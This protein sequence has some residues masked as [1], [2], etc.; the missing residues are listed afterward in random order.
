MKVSGI[1]RFGRNRAGKMHPVLVAAAIFSLLGA[2]AGIAAASGVSLPFSSDGT[3]INGCYSTGGQLKV[4]TPKQTTCPAG[5]TPIQ[6]NVTGPAGAQGPAG[7]VGPTG[8]TGP[9][10]PVG[11]V[12]PAGPTGPTGAT[13]P[14]GP[15]GTN[16]AAGQT[17]PSGEYVTGFDLTGNIVCASLPGPACPANS[18]L[19]FSVTS[20]PTATL[21]YWTGGSQTL[22]LSGNP[23]CSVTVENPSGV[24]N[25]VPATNG[26]VITSWNGFTSATGVVETPSC[27]GFLSSASVNGNYP[28]CSNASTVLESGPSSDSFVV[29]AS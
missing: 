21:E 27:G 29:T 7:P 24:I 28:V 19:T 6:W 15:A 23:N 25:G 16:V 18:T 3:T 5:M 9:Q 26:W 14:Q 4:L 11:P 22:S 20:S 10:G 2:T 8:A 17:C 1:L 12:G 13:G